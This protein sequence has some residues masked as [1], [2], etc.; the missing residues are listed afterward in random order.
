MNNDE[1]KIAAIDALAIVSD[2]SLNPSEYDFARAVVALARFA[3]IK[4]AT[5]ESL[6]GGMVAEL[7]TAVP[8][9]SQVFNGSLVAYTPEIKIEI[10]KVSEQFRADVI[11]ADVAIEMAQGGLHLLRADVVLACTGVAGPD[12]SA[13]HEPG[14]VHIAIATDS[15]VRSVSLQFSGSRDDIRVQTTL[16]MFGLAIDWLLAHTK[17]ERPKIEVS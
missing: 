11:R 14:E 9:A 16:A 6:T 7:I 13:G 12:S 2:K 4:L 8:G 10:L 5:A 1:L 15:Q 17:L 3:G